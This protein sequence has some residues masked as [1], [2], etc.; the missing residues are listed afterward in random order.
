MNL[1]SARNAFRCRLI[2]VVSGTAVVLA[3]MPGVLAAQSAGD[4]AGWNALVVTPVGALPPRASDTVWGD[5]ARTEL[6][7][8]YGR[9]RYDIDD[10]IHN[11]LG[12]T[13]ARPLG[14]ARTA[15]AATVAYLSASCGGCA[16][17]LSGG[18]EVQTRLIDAT[19]AGDG[20]SPA[21]ASLGLRAS[22]GGARYLGQG[23]ATASS[24]A[25]GATIGVAFPSMWS[26]RVAVSVMPGVGIGRFSSV[27]ETAYGTR[28][29]LGAGLAWSLR[30]VVID[31]GLQRIYVADGPTQAG[32]GLTWRMQ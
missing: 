18:I 31:M 27:D 13:I 7:F 5:S 15:V 22:A 28:P 20:A 4:L 24:I 26:S 19:I 30:S 14:V 8:R 25:G 2:R 16:A 10:A 11:G 21:T 6:S 9:W 1:S 23:G 12:I 17:W 3:T 29:I 32:A